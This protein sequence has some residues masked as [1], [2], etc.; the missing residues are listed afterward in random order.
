MA[1]QSPPIDAVLLRQ[2]VA[3][4]QGG[5]FDVAKQLYRSLLQIHPDHV[6]ANYNLGLLEFQSGRTAA[7]LVHLKTALEAEPSELQYWQSYANALLKSGKPGEALAMV[8]LALQQG[9]DAPEL[10]AVRQAAEAELERNVDPPQGTLEPLFDLF[11]AGHYAEMENQA[12]LLSVQHPQCGQLWKI[13]GVSRQ[14]QGKSALDA[15][16]RAARLLPGDA[17]AHYNLGVAQQQSGHVNDAAASFER[18]LEIQPEF[19]MAHNNLGNARQDLGQLQ[20][21][22]ASYRRALELQADFAEAHNNLGNVQKRLE[23]LDDAVL[24]YRQALALQPDFVEA[25][26]NLGAVQQLLGHLDEAEASY[27]ETLRLSPDFVEAHSNLGNVLRLQ[28]KP[29]QALESCGR[30][31]QLSPDYADALANGGLALKELGR[32]DE[33]AGCFRRVL[34][35]RPENAEAYYNLAGV[36]QSQGKDAD[37]AANFRRALELKPG[38]AEAHLTLGNVMLDLGEIDEAAS[39]YRRAAELKPDYTSANGNL[40]FVMNYHPDKSAEEIFAAYREYD[41]RFGQ[42]HRG[43]WQPHSNSREPGRRLKVGYVSPDFRHHSARH[44]LEPL[45]ARHDKAQV[46]VY[47]YAEVAQEDEVSARYKSHVDHWLNTTGLTDDE[48]VRRIRGDGIDILVDLAGHTDRNRLQV[49]TRKPAPVTV[50]WLGYG[51]TTGL[52]A[53]DYLLT[54]GTSAPEGSERLFAEQPWRLATP[55]YAYR[56]GTDMGEPGPLPAL[57]RGHLTYGTLTRAVRI[58]HRTVAVWSEILQ[59]VKGA[60][61]VINSGNFRDPAVQ[62]RLAQ[63]FA[64]HGIERER[65][66]IGYQSPPWDVLRGIDIGLDCFPHNS[67]TTLFESLYLGVPFVTLAGRPSVGRLGSSILEGAGHPEW[68][69]RTEQEYV[70]KAVALGADLERLSRQRASLRAEMQASALMDEA[71]FARKVEQAYHEMFDNWARG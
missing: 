62:D 40:L 17:E 44:F 21:A 60:R 68:I 63:R 39:N 26:N 52:T 22:A 33:A 53:I 50:S 20:Q 45:L 35:L 23:R 34:E 71:G 24:S 41:E 64:T 56:P 61:L 31:L 66:E 25:H 47:A 19:A 43:E 14:M 9:L 48:L 12:A 32:F 70:E 30:A 58:N 15:F 42:R 46:E 11:Q 51:Y 37:A 27:R 69:A 65:L 49:F 10:Q 2:A 57:E 55:Q 36:Q 54:D 4:H 28:G 16:Q 38:Y 29:E 67:G 8:R 7:A 13:L 3:H 1:S 59:R 5:R 6:D 18:A